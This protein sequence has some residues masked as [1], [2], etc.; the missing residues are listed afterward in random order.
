MKKQ[1]QL[2]TVKLQFKY[3]CSF[4]FIGDLYCE[5]LFPFFLDNLRNLFD[6]EQL[7]LLYYQRLCGHI[8]KFDRISLKRNTYI[9]MSQT[10]KIDYY[11]LC[12]SK[13]D[14]KTIILATYELKHHLFL[15]STP[16]TNGFPF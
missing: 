1:K 6:K 8:D 10:R 15:S 2:K 16:V 9:H 11:G 4:D 3:L 12:V 5:I 13:D 14:N 7:I